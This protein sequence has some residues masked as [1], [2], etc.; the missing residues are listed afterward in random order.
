MGQSS[1]FGLG[2]SVLAGLNGAEHTLSVT[3][4]PFGDT[5]HLCRPAARIHLDD[6]GPRPYG[7][8]V[9]REAPEYA[10]HRG[11]ERCGANV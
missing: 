1:L 6:F 8:A 7:H 4:G 5:A 3:P 10:S 2:L 11:D 9:V